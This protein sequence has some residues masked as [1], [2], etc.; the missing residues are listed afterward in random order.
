[1]PFWNSDIGDCI[2]DIGDIYMYLFI[3]T[4]W[5]QKQVAMLMSFKVTGPQRECR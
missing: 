3:W 5:V 2:G 1:M 4:E